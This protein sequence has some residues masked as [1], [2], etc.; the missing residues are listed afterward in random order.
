MIGLNV[1]IFFFL[2]KIKRINNAGLFS[3]LLLLTF[4]KGANISEGQCIKPKIKPFIYESCL[5]CVSLCEWMAQMPIFIN[6]RTVSASK[7]E[8][9]NI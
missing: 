5:F 7:Y 2:W 1:V 6:A 9:M 4:I 8:Y 3:Q